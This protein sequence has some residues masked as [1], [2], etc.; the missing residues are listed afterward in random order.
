MPPRRKT[1]SRARARR[2]GGWNAG[3]AIGRLISARMRNQKRLDQ[4]ASAQA[5]LEEAG[6]EAHSRVS[7]YGTT[8][9]VSPYGLPN[10]NAVY[11]RGGYSLGKLSR[12]AAG[13]NIGRALIKRAT[14][15]ISGSGMYTGR[16]AYEG[17]S[18][19]SDV[20]PQ[21]VSSAAD[22]TGAVTVS[23]LEFLSEIFGPSTPF[24]IQS[25]N[26]NPG[27]E[28]MFPWLSQIAQNYEEYELLQLVV[29]FRSTT[30]DIG[31]TSNGQC[32]TIIMATNYD[33]SAAPFTDK[34]AMM[35]YDGA[36][37]SKT[38]ESMA[39]GVECDPSKLSGSAGKYVRAFGLDSTK[40]IK[41]Y[42]HGVLQVAVANAPTQL[43]NYS[44]GELWVSYTVKLRKP[45]FFTGR[46]LGISRDIWV[47]NGLEATT[48]PFSGAPSS[49]LKAMCN[50]IGTALSS[51]GANTTITFPAAY[52]GVVAILIR[53]EGTNFNVNPNGGVTLGG[54]VS[55]YKDM[56]ASGTTSSDAPDYS[57]GTFSTT[58]YFGEFHVRVIPASGGVDNTFTIAWNATT[59]AASQA[60]IEIKEINSGFSYRYANLGANDA[61]IL[62]NSSGTVVTV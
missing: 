19:M 32:G 25:F 21:V 24:N 29:S 46:G 48:N 17:N 18:L 34:A 41:D 11:G 22:E 33:A 59:A 31:T 52:A 28:S 35:A 6:A 53:A 13:K 27:L 7:A 36:M 38:T 16:G 4:I 26:I 12:T 61:P 9:F 50:N 57:G 3:S 5:M 60:T 30:T 40:D 1:S 2:S 8:R 23:R 54:N 39:H 20:P 58:G 62:I 47:T 56:Y 37:S 42:D 44:L 55:S 14:G 51:T 45:K 15:L 10:V 43:A 49:M